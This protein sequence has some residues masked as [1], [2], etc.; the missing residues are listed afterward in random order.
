MEIRLDI[1]LNEKYGFSSRSHAKDAIQEGRIWVNGKIITKPAFKVKENDLIQIADKEDD[2]ASRGGNKLYAAIKKWA[3]N[4]NGKTVLDVGAS[5][6]GFTDV[7]LKENAAFVFSVDIGKDQLI[8]RLKQD[9]RVKNMEG[10][11]CRYLT[12]DMF[13]RKIDF[14]CMDVSFISI[15]K[16]VDALLQISSLDTTFVFLIKPQFEAGK[17]NIGKNGIVKDKK[18]HKKVLEDFLC[19]FNEKGFRVLHLMRSNTVGRDGN[20]EYLI[21]L[22]RNQ[23]LAIRTFHLDRIIKGLE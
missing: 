11:N 21:H 20:Q 14:I 16:I 8:P 17:E 9:S 13:D 5:T 1:L 22:S 12:K 15:K 23:E 7:C 19:Y 4:L 10:I 6:G 18:I 3:I 2:F